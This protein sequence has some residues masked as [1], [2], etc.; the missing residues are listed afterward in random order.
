MILFVSILIMYLLSRKKGTTIM[1]LLCGLYLI[2]LFA[3]LLLNPSVFFMADFSVVNYLYLIIFF[4][5]FFLPWVDCSVKNPIVLHCN[6]KDYSFYKLMKLTGIIC[7]VINIFVYILLTSIVT[8]YSS[9]KN[10]DEGELILTQLP[11]GASLIAYIAQYSSLL[12]LALPYHFYF[13]RSGNNKESVWS[14]IIALNF[15]LSGLVSFSRS[16]MVLFILIYSILYIYF[17]RSF[18]K[19]LS[20]SIRLFLLTSVVI[21][22]GIFFSITSNRFAGD[23]IDVSERFMYPDALITN[24]VVNSQLSYFS[25]WYSKSNTYLPIYDGDITYGSRTFPLVALILSRTGMTQPYPD[26]L[27]KELDIQFG[28][29]VGSFLGCATVYLYDYG[30]LLAICSLLLYFFV[31][32]IKLKEH[33]VDVVDFMLVIIFL[34]LPCSGIF[35][36]AMNATYWHFE[37]LLFI[38]LR[39]L[40]PHRTYKTN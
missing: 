14:L 4:F 38:V 1:T 8:D 16:R 5:L 25:Q 28:N 18:V 3:A 20:R 10:G 19:K 37:I 22:A 6:T 9:Y 17:R 32:K 13:L 36:T 12:I 33:N 2:S 35:N 21:V 29:D 23:N 39:F 24:P 7:F 40:S 15:V 26:Y 27:E 31:L 11:I 34:Q 30:Y